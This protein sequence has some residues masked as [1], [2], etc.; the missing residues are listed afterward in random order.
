[1]TLHR[2]CCCD[3]T[4]G[5]GGFDGYKGGCG[6]GCRSI[7]GLDY[8]CSQAGNVPACTP[9]LT[10]SIDVSVCR[11]M[12]EQDGGTIDACEGRDESDPGDCYD[13]DQYPSC[14]CFE[15]DCEKVYDAQRFTLVIG[16]GGWDKLTA[17]GCHY[18]CTVSLEVGDP[19]GFSGG[20]ADGGCCIGGVCSGGT[21]VDCLAAGGEYLGDD[22]DCS[23][24]PCGECE[25]CLAPL[26]SE[27]VADT[28]DDPMSLCCDTCDPPKPLAGWVENGV[29][30]SCSDC[31]DTPP[32][33]SE[34]YSNVNVDESGITLTFTFGLNMSGTGWS[35]YLTSVSGPVGFDIDGTYNETGV[36]YRLYGEPDW[37]VPNSNL[38]YGCGASIANI[39]GTSWGCWCSPDS[40]VLGETITWG[41]TWYTGF[42]MANGDVPPSSAKPLYATDYYKCD[43]WEMLPGHP[44]N[45][46]DDADFEA[47]GSV[48]LYQ[49]VWLGKPYDAEFA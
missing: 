8:G 22:S 24:C 3:F 5:D 49:R 42:G 18:Q 29:L 11:Y 45:P 2:N 27:F 21:E 48:G 20:G 32:I 10:Y 9:T 43:W 40:N 6:G 13:H 12:G 4:C 35:S 37:P 46:G 34:S 47:C 41:D 30:V 15:C 36:V 23:D 1:M 25:C 16:E 17:V 7:G 28:S 33:S 38:A 14:C 26:G 31:S 19:Y 44:G 39:G